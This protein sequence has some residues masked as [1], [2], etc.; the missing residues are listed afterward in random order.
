MPKIEIVTEAAELSLIG[1]PHAGSHA[2]IGQAFQ[3]LADQLTAQALWD[4]SGAW[5]AIYHNSPGAVA[6]PA[7]RSHAACVF[8]AEAPLPD[9]F[10]RV[11]L[12]AGRYA[13]LLHA[14]PYA[15]LPESWMWFRQT[16]MGAAGFAPAD[17]PSAEMYLNDPEFTAPEDLRTRL[18]IPIAG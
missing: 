10:D 3:R 14:G 18:L 9:G 17:G 11:V 7:L 15:G 16:G 4:R 13:E 1:V 2:G 6:E 5:A 8:P 12:P